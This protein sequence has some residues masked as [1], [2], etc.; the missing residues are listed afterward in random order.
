MRSPFVW[1]HIAILLVI[2]ATFALS[3]ATV[4]KVHASFRSFPLPLGI[5]L[6]AS[7]FVYLLLSLFAVLL[8]LDLFYEFEFSYDWRPNLEWRKIQNGMTRH[9][10]IELLGYP[11]THIRFEYYY[12]LFP[13]YYHRGTIKFE[14]DPS[15]LADQLQDKVDDSAKVIDKT[16]ERA[17]S[18]W[19]PGGFPHWLS[20]HVRGTIA[21]L[22]ALTLLILALLSLIPF[23]LRNGWNSWILYVPVMALVAATLYEK[24]TQPGWRFDQFFLVPM[25]L[26]IMGTWGMRM[27]AVLASGRP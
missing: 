25:Y 17:S 23:S 12:L 26:L 10:V 7:A 3:I 14:G 20:D 13:L 18:E 4:Y 16:P 11:D 19:L 5:A 27:W 15:K 6:R 9:Q 22:S 8:T 2:A 24:A 1:R 21:P